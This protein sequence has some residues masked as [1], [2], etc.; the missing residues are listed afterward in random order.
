MTRRKTEQGRVRCELIRLD[1]AIAK[2]IVGH[3]TYFWSFDQKRGVMKLNLG[4]SDQYMAAL[5]F[6]FAG[7]IRAKA[8]LCA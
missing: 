3:Q 2:M 8:E 1:A 4:C 7:T 5:G 6:I